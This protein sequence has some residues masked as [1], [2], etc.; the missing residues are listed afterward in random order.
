MAMA[1]EDEESPTSAPRTP[2]PALPS[3]SSQQLLTSSS[4]K[5]LSLIDSVKGF[6]GTFWTKAS[7]LIK[8][9]ET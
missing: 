9:L 8:L 6:W 1:D 5:N 2:P 7:Y 4:N 3:S